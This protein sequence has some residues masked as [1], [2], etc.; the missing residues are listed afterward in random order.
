MNRN[1]I[2]RFSFY[3][4]L[5]FVLGVPEVRSRAEDEGEDAPKIAPEE[6]EARVRTAL[7]REGELPVTIKAIGSFGPRRQSPTAV[8]SL[9]GGIV[10][11]VT[12]HEGDEVTSGAMIARLDSRQAENELAKNRAALRSAESEL[13]K[14]RQGGMELEQE[15]LEGEVKAAEAALAQAKIE[16]ERK[17]SLLKEGLIAE[18]AA[19]VARQAAEEAARKAKLARG[20]LENFK[21]TGKSEDMAKLQAEADQARSELEI[22]AFKASNTV[23]RAHQPGRISTLN[24]RKGAA[25]E[26]NAVIA[27]IAGGDTLALKMMLAPADADHVSNNAA[28]FVQCGAATATL[29]GRVVSVGGELD[30]ETGLVPIEAELLP[31]TGVRFRIGEFA[32]S[33]VVKNL[34]AKGWIIPISALTVED[35]KPFIRVV[36]E[37]QIAHALPVEV[38]ARSA[39][40]A[41]VRAEGIA[42]GTRV[43]IAGNYNLPDGAHVV[44]EPAE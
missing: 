7:V 15:N 3:L 17:E 36:D 22:A 21:S 8:V 29:E 42:E 4:L 25:V 33:E 26:A 18:N 13:K 19:V 10:A 40:L 35:D 6:L 41:A 14:A 27:Q 43:I 32:C 44:E 37:K 20:K 34:A 28:V 39:A 30:P 12:V 31:Q 24:I 16:A 5:G 1:R 38:L 11:D 23:I 9:V 2:T